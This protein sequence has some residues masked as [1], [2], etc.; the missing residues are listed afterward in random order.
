MVASSTRRGHILTQDEARDLWLPLIATNKSCFQCGVE[1]KE[2][3]LSESGPLKASPQ[4]SDPN[5]PSYVD[6]CVV[7]CM[8]CNNFNNDTPDSEI[9]ALLSSVLPH[10]NASIRLPSAW[11]PEQSIPYVPDPIPT[12]EPLDPSFISWVDLHLGSSTRVGQWLHHENNP[13]RRNHRPVT[14]TREQVIQM[15]RHNGGNWCRFF[16]L[17]G[18][19]V[20]GHPML[21][22][23]DKIDPTMGY[24]NGNLMIIS[25]R[26]NNAKWHHPVKFYPD[27]LRIRDS[28]L[29]R[30]SQ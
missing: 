6:N 15:Y 25:V 11:T 24:E 17:R 10:S 29:H 22:T 8:F 21:L 2:S 27:L 5:N 14:V 23:I 28:L 12:D 26:A 4:R 30:F 20:P 9:E 16:G 1:V 7:F 3:S 19:W 13:N 18:S